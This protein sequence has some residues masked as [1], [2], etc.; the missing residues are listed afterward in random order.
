MMTNVLI[1]DKNAAYPDDNESILDK[2]VEEQ[3]DEAEKKSLY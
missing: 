1:T 2:E 3:R